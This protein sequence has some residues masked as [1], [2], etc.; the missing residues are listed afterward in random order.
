VISGR[1]V[2]SAV[3]SSPAA[4]EQLV[5]SPWLALTPITEIIVLGGDRF[6][7]EGD[8]KQVEAQIL[9]AARG[10]LMELAWMTEAETGRRLGLNPEHVVLLRALSA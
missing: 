5:P 4:R 9:S 8:A 7:V 3:D 1:A 2:H 6:Q 10:S